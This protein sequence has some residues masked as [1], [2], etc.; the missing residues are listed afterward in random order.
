MADEKPKSVY[1]YAA[2]AGLLMSLPLITVAASV[3]LA[4]KLPMIG[5]IAFPALMLAPAL[6]FMQMKRVAVETPSYCSFYP[7]WLFGIYTML[8]ATLICS[9]AATLYLMFVEPT[10]ISTYFDNAIS[11]MQ[12]LAMQPGGEGFAEQV[13]FFVT[14]KERRMLPSVDELVASMGWL[15]AFTGAVIAAVVARCFVRYSYRFAADLSTPNRK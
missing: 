6:L 11:S 9:L 10:F 14:A 3:L 2:E 8:G 7:L 4:N 12:T 1:L 15:S 13:D 5:V